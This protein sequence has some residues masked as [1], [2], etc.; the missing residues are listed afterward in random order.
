[1][2]DKPEPIDTPGKDKK[3]PLVRQAPAL[4][5]GRRGVLNA[6]V[7]LAAIGGLI[8]SPWKP[9]PAAAPRIKPK[10]AS[11][12]VRRVRAHKRVRTRMQQA[13]RRANRG[14]LGRTKRKGEQ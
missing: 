11:G 14:T 9:I 10:R 5:S 3:E 2:Q 12:A 13:S 7:G 1:M 6:A 4:Y 8:T